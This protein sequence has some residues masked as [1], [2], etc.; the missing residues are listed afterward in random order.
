MADDEVQHISWPS[1][2]TDLSCVK[3][4]V[5]KEN[6]TDIGEEVSEMCNGSSLH[7]CKAD[8]LVLDTCAGTMASVSGS[9]QE[10]EH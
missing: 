5:E 10:L 2:V 7:F 8:E 9:P 3:N 1:E 6:T 4:D